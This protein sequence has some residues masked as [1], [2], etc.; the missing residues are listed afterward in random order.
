MI[1]GTCHCGTVEVEVPGPPEALTLCN[2]SSCRRYGALWAY[3]PI[4]A[5]RITGHP[6]HT[7]EYVWGDKTLRTVRCRYCGCITHWEPL[8]PLVDS[9]LGVNMRNFHPDEIGTPRLRRFD[10]AESWTYLDAERHPHH[11]RIARPVSNLERTVEMYC[12][13]LCLDELGRFLDHEGFDGVMLGERGGGHHLEFTRCRTHPVSPA[14]TPE[15]LLVFYLPDAEEWNQACR[16]MLES[17]FTEVA[18]YNPYW[19]SRGRTFEDPDR[20]RV[21]LQQT[22]WSNVPAS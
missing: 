6:E 14:P 8:Q 12:S 21:V 5:V 16:R 20:Y 17:G 3:F 1:T 9:K 13:G 15:D 2:C 19:A 22:A 11:L 7:T 18:P 4:E 10:G